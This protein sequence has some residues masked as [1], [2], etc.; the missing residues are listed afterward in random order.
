MKIISFKFNSELGVY[1]QPWT[2]GC[3]EPAEET[4]LPTM[5]FSPSINVI[6]DR[7]QYGKNIA[8]M[9]IQLK[10]AGEQAKRE[11]CAFLNF[12]FEPMPYLLS[13]VMMNQSSGFRACTDSVLPRP[14]KRC[15]PYPF[16]R[17]RDFECERTW[18]QVWEKAV[19]RS[20]K[21]D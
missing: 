5:T 7:V 4:I 6:I 16:T 18:K 1:M 17:D 10:G 15:L 19:R 11:K 21:K 20:P 8:E 2:W 12:Y 14:L 9:K 13:M 3:Q